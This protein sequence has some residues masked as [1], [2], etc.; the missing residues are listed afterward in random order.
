LDFRIGEKRV[1]KVTRA[2]P[3]TLTLHR[4]VE[5]GVS[6]LRRRDISAGPD[7]SSSGQ[8]KNAKPQKWPG[9]RDVGAAATN[10]AGDPFSCGAPEDRQEV[11][12][13]SPSQ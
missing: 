6:R 3:L 2:S 11:D 13:E 9:K 4:G 10:A 1:K 7:D 8:L 5:S 12:G